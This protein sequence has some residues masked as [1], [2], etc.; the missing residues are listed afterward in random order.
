MIY[1]I[2]YVI[3]IPYRYYSPVCIDN[4]TIPLVDRSRKSGLDHKAKSN[5]YFQWVSDIFLANVFR[6]TEII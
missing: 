6:V 1:V 5:Y 2:I 4:N 3:T